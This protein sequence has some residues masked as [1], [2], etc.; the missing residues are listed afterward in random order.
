M[1]V[2]KNKGRQLSPFQF[3][4]FYEQKKKKKKKKGSQ[5]FGAGAVENSVSAW[6]GCTD[7][8]SMA[9][10]NCLLL[11]FLLSTLPPFAGDFCRA[12]AVF[13]LGGCSGLAANFSAADPFSGAGFASLEGSCVYGHYEIVSTLD[14]QGNLSNNIYE[15]L[16]CLCS[17]GET[18]GEA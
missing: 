9:F 15:S 14:L 6:S 10:T 17:G 12:I 16:R 3:A 4:C 2:K 13:L 1:Q 5:T 18:V 8:M 7:V 11:L